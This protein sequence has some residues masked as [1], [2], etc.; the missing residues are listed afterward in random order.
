MKPDAFRRQGWHGLLTVPSAHP[1]PP[2]IANYITG[3]PILSKQ[4]L[5]FVFSSGRHLAVSLTLVEA[6][7]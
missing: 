4:T 7:L 2:K 6:L 1:R 5:D 3:T